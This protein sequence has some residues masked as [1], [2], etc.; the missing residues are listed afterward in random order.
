MRKMVIRSTATISS[1]N[2]VKYLQGAV[3]KV[4]EFWKGKRLRDRIL[5][6]FL[7][8]MVLLC[9]LGKLIPKHHPGSTSLLFGILS[10]I[11]LGIYFV[12]GIAKNIKNSF[13]YSQSKIFTLKRITLGILVFLNYHVINVLVDKSYM[14]INIYFPLAVAFPISTF[15]SLLWL[16]KYERK[17][18]IVY[19]V[20]TEGIE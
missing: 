18:G 12:I 10:G 13:Y 7:F 8:G 6:A 16:L 17:N 20:K 11:A 14:L 4:M 2:I 15:I 3:E 5:F 9:V 1:M 19:I